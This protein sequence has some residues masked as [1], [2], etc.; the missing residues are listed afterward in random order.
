[1]LRRQAGRHRRGGLANRLATSPVA[2][3]FGVP[4]GLR[5]AHEAYL[6]GLAAWES[7]SGSPAMIYAQLGEEEKALD[8]IEKDHGEHWATGDLSNEPAFDPLRS[9][10]RFV[11]LLRTAGVLR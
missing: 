4:A 2:L 3:R 11:R 8:L 5:K 6:Q 10:P 7:F 9:D 1:M